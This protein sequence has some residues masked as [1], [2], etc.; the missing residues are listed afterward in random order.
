MKLVHLSVASV[1]GCLLGLAALIGITLSSLGEFQVKQDELAQLLALQGRSAN[2]SVASNSLLL[3]G[4]DAALLAAYQ[5]EGKVLQRQLR[6][7]GGDSAGARKAG[8]RIEELLDRVTAQIEHAATPGAMAP[9]TARGALELPVRSRIVMHQVAELGGALDAALDTLLRER[10]EAIAHEASWIAATLAGAALLFG[11]LAVI[12]FVLIHRRVAVPARALSGTLNAIRAGDEHA[13]APVHGNDE[14]A[15]LA[16]TLN[17]MLDERQILDAELGAHHERLVQLHDLLEASEDLCGIIDADYRY[18]WVNRSYRERYGLQQE[19]IET[20]TV[21]QVL[22]EAYF[23][24]SAKPRIDRCFAGDVQRYETEREYPGLGWRKLLVCYYPLVVPGRPEPRIGAVITDVT[25]IRQAEAAL[26]R[27]AALLDMAGRTARFGGWSVD[28]ANSTL[29]W[30]NVVADTL[31]MPRGHAISFDEGIALYAPEFRERIRGRFV[32]CAEQGVPYDEELQVIAADEQRLWVRTVGEAVRDEDGRIVRVLGTIQDVTDRREREEELRKL[33]H[34]VEQSPAPVGITDTEGRFVYVNPAFERSSGYGREE[35]LG[36]TPARIQGGQT[37]DAVYRELWE[38]ITA[39]GVWSGELENRRKDGSL[40]WEHEVIS[41]LT[42]EQGQLTSYVL[43]K[44]D[45]TAFKDAEQELRASRNELAS[46]L[47]SRK[48]LINALPAHIA[49][50]DDEGRI[51]DVNE[52]WRHFGEANAYAGDDFGLG[53]NYIRLCETASGDCADEAGDVA[54]GLRAVL[55]GK[56]DTFA[57]EYPCHAPDR[58]RWFRVMANRLSSGEEDAPQRG[59]VV[60]HIDITER[61][62]AEQE[63]TRIAFEDPLTGLYSRNGFTSQL[64]QHIDRGGWPAAAAVVMIDII[65]QRDVNAAHGYDAGDRLLIEVGQRL[66]E[67]ARSQQ[68]FAGR[69]GGDEFM[70]FLLPVAGEGLEQSL[71]WLTESLSVPITLNAIK[72]EIAYRLGYTRIG[73][74]R[75]PIQDLLREAELALFRHRTEPALEWVAYESSLRAENLQRIELTRELRRGLE[76]D[77]FELHFQP[78]VDLA[79]GTLVSCEALLRWNHPTKG[80][81]RPD[82]FIPIAEQSQLIGPIG[83]WALRRACRHLRDWRDAGLT[84]VRVSVNVS[85]VQFQ[86]GDFTAQVRDALEAFDVAASELALEITES[87]FERESDALL[88][89]IRALHELGVWL[90]LDDFGTG[91]SSLLYLQRYP[92]DEIKIDQGFVARLLED[93]F[94]RDIVGTVTGLAR[95]LG[96]EV[97]AEGI[98]S[99]EVAAA[100]LAMDCR[101]GQGYFYSMPLEAEDFRWLLERH[102]RLPLRAD[103]SR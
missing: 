91:Y 62:L 99:A 7:V 82:V 18:L 92:F 40:Y 45:I 98:E 57:L 19:E 28:L 38:T 56:R 52:Q 93:A 61:K 101:F 8:H 76:E 72:I 66:T 70:L 51:V 31:G 83:D 53:L 90:S 16:A 6:Q 1:F 60:M 12:A 65:G 11:A 42:D 39:G 27:Q 4:A 102:S 2:F 14:L 95:A 96:A 22:G 67:R 79:S 24:E 33:A 100:L 15:D 3:F 86:T 9:A 30:S 25:E 69:I 84:L 36:D 80:L 44:Q 74:Q 85:L 68:G 58:L 21:A 89:Q 55:D 73:R 46:L 97:V 10:R 47:E 81:I 34:I 54:A 35:L 23:L 77:Q 49:L 78:K 48:A 103:G 87:V 94:S 13:R 88:R 26:A 20:R 17:R 64:Q 75:R 43:I 32:A 29:E 63:I 50:L 59:A 37:P 41:P 71:V 5:R